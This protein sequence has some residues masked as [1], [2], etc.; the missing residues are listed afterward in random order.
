MARLGIRHL[1]VHSSGLRW[2]DRGTK[3]AQPTHRQSVTSVQERAT[4][5]AE[6]RGG[7]GLHA[8]T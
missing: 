2:P 1:R 5:P 6:T 8:Q 7:L 3:G 4:A